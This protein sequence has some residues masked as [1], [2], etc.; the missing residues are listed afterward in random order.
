M[1]TVKQKRQPD[2]QTQ[3]RSHNVAVTETL[4]SAP[5]P[6]DTDRRGYMSHINPPLE[7]VDSFVN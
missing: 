1:G 2:M 7:N 3:S 5:P 6:Q 4:E